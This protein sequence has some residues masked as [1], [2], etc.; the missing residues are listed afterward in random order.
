[1]LR[2]L[3]VAAEVLWAANFIK[4][5]GGKFYQHCKKEHNTKK[6]KLKK[7]TENEL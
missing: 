1:M 6:E 3:I 5:Q 2:A 7:D 4:E